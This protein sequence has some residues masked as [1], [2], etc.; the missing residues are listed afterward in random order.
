M[1]LGIPPGTTGT[2]HAVPWRPQQVRLKVDLARDF[3]PCCNP[4]FAQATLRLLEAGQAAAKNP[5][6]APGAQVLKQGGPGRNGWVG[7][8][9]GWSGK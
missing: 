7:S 3:G 2:A 6:P 9:D 4:H 5:A 1:L 8:A